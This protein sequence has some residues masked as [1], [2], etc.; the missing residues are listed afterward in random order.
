MDTAYN[1]CGKPVGP[2]GLVPTYSSINA[3][4]VDGT[5]SSPVPPVS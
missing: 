4:V 1:H 5:G 2:L 3:K